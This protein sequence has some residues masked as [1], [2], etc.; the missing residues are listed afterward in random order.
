MIE[1]YKTLRDEVGRTPSQRVQIVS[2]GM[3]TVGVL[4]VAAVTGLVHGL[5]KLVP[6]IIL[7]L[8]VPMTCL[9]AL[10]SWFSEAQRGRRASFY[11]RGLE[12][13]I[14]SE[15]K[16]PA[17]AWEEGLRT[18][19]DQANRLELFRGHYWTVWGAFSLL[20]AVSAPMGAVF[21][22]A[23]IQ[24]HPWANWSCVQWVSVVVSILAVLLVSACYVP[25]IMRFRV[26][27]EEG[28]WPDAI[29]RQLPPQLG[30]Q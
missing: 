11:L 10:H 2:L 21:T 28:K 29:K 9:T 22:I 13:W 3:A 16:Q 12:R 20:A 18:S 6:G 23:G 17:L 1:E 15:L 25:R 27:D 7:L 8:I 14:N 4:L 30:G 5:N 26:F 19:S 24:E